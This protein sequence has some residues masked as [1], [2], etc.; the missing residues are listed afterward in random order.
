MLS[1]LLFNELGGGQKEG[2]EKEGGACTHTHTHT[3]THTPFSV[4]NGPPKVSHVFSS[5]LVGAMSACVCV[6]GTLMCI[7][8]FACF[9]G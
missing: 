7:R 3:H 5:L 4:E 1:L 9:D 8:M 6:W 2:G